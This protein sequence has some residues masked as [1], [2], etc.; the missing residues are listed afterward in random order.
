MINPNTAAHLGS[1]DWCHLALFPTIK[2]GAIDTPNVLRY[3]KVCLLHHVLG[4]LKLVKWRH[5]NNDRY[6]HTSI[7]L[8]C[9]LLFVPIHCGRRRLSTVT[10]T[11]HPPLCQANH[12]KPLEASCST[13]FGLVASGLVLPVW[14][15]SDQYV[16]NLAML[17]DGFGLVVAGSMVLPQLV[18]RHQVLPWWVWQQRVPRHWFWRLSVW[19]LSGS[20]SIGYIILMLL[21]PSVSPRLQEAMLPNPMWEKPQVCPCH[22][23]QMSQSTN[24]RINVW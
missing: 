9:P 12:D 19:Q 22:F 5:L 1:F 21:K 23:W 6:Y 3:C 17:I 8:L 18:V 11:H 2:C 20:S 7:I 4:F 13:A 16:F 24:L 15:L 10:P 14:H